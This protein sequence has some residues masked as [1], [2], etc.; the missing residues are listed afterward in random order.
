MSEP[1]LDG[2]EP[3][4]FEAMAQ[5]LILN[6]NTCLLL[7]PHIARGAMPTPRD[8]NK[9]IQTAREVDKAVGKR[10]HW[11]GRPRP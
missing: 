8:I 1:D 5:R 6:V 3:T 11:E 9:A 2:P 10:I 7:V 4:P